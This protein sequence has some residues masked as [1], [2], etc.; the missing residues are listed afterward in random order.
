MNLY[1]LSQDD[2]LGYGTYDSCI[3]A[4]PNEETA[5]LI[6]PSELDIKLSGKEDGIDPD[7]GQIGWPETEGGYWCTPEKVKV[8]LIGS[9]K[10]GTEQGVILASYNDG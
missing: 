9:A 10:E 6:H 7:M 8:E 4:A 5:R 1:L 2:N 3:V